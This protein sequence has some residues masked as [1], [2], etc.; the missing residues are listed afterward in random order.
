M[1]KYRSLKPVTYVDNGKVVSVKEGR[2]FTLTDEQAK[3]LAGSVVLI[4]VDSGSMFP[5]GA[6]IIDPTIVRTV[7]N[8]PVAGEAVE[9]TPAPVKTVVKPHTK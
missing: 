2:E 8:T 3:A 9:P 4:D 1:A 7:P 6:P 5:D